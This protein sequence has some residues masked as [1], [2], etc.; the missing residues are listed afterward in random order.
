MIIDSI[1]SL[2]SSFHS[3]AG[4]LL[5]IFSA[6]TA[7]RIVYLLIGVFFTRKFKHTDNYHKYAILI[8][9]RNEEPVL[10]NLLD[11]IKKQD[12][13]SNLIT[14]FVVADNCTDNTAKIAREEGAV[15]YERFDKTRCTKGYA[16][17]FLFENIKKDYGIEAFEGYFIFDADNLLKT[18]YISRM[19]DAF[20]AGVK[21]LTSYRNTKNFDENWISSI[22][23]LHWIRSIRARHRARSVLRLA[24]NIQGTGFLFANELVREGWKYTSLTEDR[25]FTADAVAKG[26]EISY[27]DEAMFYDEQP[28]SHKISLR[29]RLRWSRGHI[30]AYFESGPKL[31]VNIFFGKMF[32]K[33]K[34]ERQDKPVK[35]LIESVRHRA[36]S[37]DT[38]I[39]LT[40]FNVFSA[41]LWFTAEFLIYSFALHKTGIDNTNLISG[42]SILAKALKLVF[43]PVISVSPGAEAVLLG[44][45]LSIWFRI[46][47]LAGVYIKDIF[48]GSFVFFLERKNIKPIPFSKKLICC[49][50]WPMFDLIG[51]FTNVLAVFMK[52]GWKPIP[53]KSKVTIDE[54]DPKLKK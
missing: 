20:D 48:Y 12:Y 52:V 50:T 43:N 23:A 51:R 13:P 24:T 46:L 41:F 15:C 54:L 45:A 22:Y 40:P 18:D 36:A 7:Y 25:A 3:V 30:L 34:N 2:Y 19:N 53:H 6:L 38:L 27:N 32:L 1:G 16:L 9:A 4:T 17:Q 26:Y 14:V 39:Q 31:F 28:V 42:S 37:F 29:Q 44:I 35:K 33:N 8:P 10:G 47:Y 21:I 49:L 11:S 5:W